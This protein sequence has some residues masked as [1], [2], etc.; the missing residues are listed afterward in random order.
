MTETIVTLKYKETKPEIIN[1]M[2]FP[3]VRKDF[4]LYALRSLVEYSPYNYHVIVVDQTQPDVEFEAKLRPYC[5]LHIKSCKYNLGYAQGVNQGLR[6]AP[7]PYITACNDDVI[8]LP[9]LYD[10]GWFEGILDTFERFETAGA[11]NPMS[12]IEPGWGYGEAA[13]REY[14]SFR[15]CFD[16]RNIEALI[17]ERNWQVIDGLVMWCTVFTKDFL[18]DVGYMHED[19]RPGGGEDYTKCCEGYQAGYR[20]LA[21]SRSWV[22]HWWGKSKDDSHGLDDALPLLGEPWCKLSTRGFGDEGLWDP[23]VAVWGSDMVDGEKIT[24][25]RTNPEIARWNYR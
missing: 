9:H 11:V 16:P 23:D 4:I 3:I 24:P 7:T 8:F 14:L 1:T 20:L 15:E 10:G 12:P 6:L 13:N 21:T 22:W 5:D 19:F 25:I 17:E 2:V 18:D